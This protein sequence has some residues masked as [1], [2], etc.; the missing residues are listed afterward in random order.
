MDIKQKIINAQ[1]IKFYIEADGLEAARA[2]LYIL[3]NDLHDQPFGFMEDVFV[4]EDYR[5]QGLGTKL[6]LELIKAAKE[7][8]CY[9]LVGTSR[10]GR[11]KVHN[12]YL[13]FGFKDWGKEFR[14]DF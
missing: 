14:M 6:I 1:G 10:C 2:Y 12:W 4:R 5:G 7:S 8:N 13:N 11:P 3:K 9:K